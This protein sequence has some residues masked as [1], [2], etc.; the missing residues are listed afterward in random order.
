MK[1]SARD[2]GILTLVAM[3]IGI[4]AAGVAIIF[5][6]RIQ[7]IVVKGESTYTAEE[8]KAA[9]AV[10]E[11]KNLFTVNTDALEQAA[12]EKLLNVENITVKRAWPH[13]LE[14]TVDP[15]RPKANF[16]TGDCTYVISAG[17]KVMRMTAEPRAGIYNVIG[18]T[19]SPLLLT[20]DRFTSSNEKKDKAIWEVIEAVDAAADKGEKIDV[21]GVAGSTT[22]PEVLI[23]AAENEEMVENI[24]NDITQID[25]TD[26]NDIVVTY[27]NR[28]KIKLGNTNDLDYKLKFASKIISLLEDNVEGTL[29]IFSNTREASF[30]DQSIIDKNEEVYKT[31]IE[32]YNAEKAGT[33][34]EE[35]ESGEEDENGEEEEETK[36]PVSME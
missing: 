22:D 1:L 16:I 18:A 33:A 28:I 15:T 31:N 30:L 5:L 26:Y 14:V 20:G 6:F 11:G 4:V 35:E 21:A 12:M 7:K 10:P 32:S 34:E 27:S 3:V 23:A 17:G 36:K 25:M 29:T 9:L 24:A 2:K 19:P 8:I 13:S